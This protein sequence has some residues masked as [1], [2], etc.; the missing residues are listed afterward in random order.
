MQSER[1]IYFFPAIIV[2]M[3]TVFNGLLAIINAQVIG[4][5]QSHVIIVEVLLTL[6]AL[7]YTAYRWQP[8]HQIWLFILICIIANYFFLI[9]YNGYVDVKVIRDAIIFPVYAAL[10]ACVNLRTVK[11]TF[12]TITA[13]VTGVLFIEIISPALFGHIFNI[14]SYYINTRDFDAS[15][16]QYSVDGLFGNSD[17]PGGRFLLGFTGWHRMSSIFLEPVSLGNYVGIA[18]IT[19][20]FFWQTASTLWRALMALCITLLLIGC[21]G[22]LASLLGAATLLGYPFYRLLPVR[23]SIFVLP[24]ILILIFTLTF[25]LSLT[26]VGDDFASRTA[27]G[28]HHLVNMKASDFLSTWHHI[29]HY[30]DAGYSYFVASQG[31]IGVIILW[32]V[33]TYTSNS[34]EQRISGYIFGIQLYIWVLLIISYSFF[35]IKI[36]AFMWFMFGALAR[37]SNN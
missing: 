26:P 9:A 25:G 24:A 22:R 27:I 12:T 28:V 7:A 6:G 32:L 23:A 37:K 13:I 8:D 3:A 29:S 14:S 4:L 2:I 35:S 17:R 36:A 5:A 18:L 1:P 11:F 30:A 34:E 21:D 16:F 15:F 33:L 10:G 19:V 20:L 31:V